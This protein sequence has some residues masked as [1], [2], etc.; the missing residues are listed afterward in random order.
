M[1]KILSFF[2]RVAKNMD[3]GYSALV[4]SKMCSSIK[5]LIWKESIIKG[6]YMG[7]TEAVPPRP[8]NRGGGGSSPRIHY[9]TYEW[10]IRLELY[11]PSFFTKETFTSQNYFH[12]IEFKFKWSSSYSKMRFNVSSLNTNITIW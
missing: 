10:T 7:G 8:V 1:L 5:F 9:H 6:V 12:L 3:K 4:I 2:Y 11:N